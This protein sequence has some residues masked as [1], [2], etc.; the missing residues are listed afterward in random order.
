MSVKIRSENLTKI[1]GDH[2]DEALELLKQGHTRDEILKETGQTI[3]VYNASFEVNEGEI[4][5]LIGLSGSGKSS[6]IRCLNGLNKLTSGSLWVDEYAIHEMD[7]KQLRKLQ[8]DKMSMVFQHFAILPN[9]T[10]RENVGF[11]LEIRD[12]PKEERYR[13]T[14]EA[15]H[16][17]G[18]ET[19]SDK[20]PGDLSG[21]MKQRVGLARALI[22]NS[23][24]LLMDEPF[25]ALDALIRSEMQE[26]LINL[27]HEIK[28]TIVFVTHDLDEALHLGDKIAIMKD[29][30]IEQMGT[31]EEIL[32][33]P[34]NE[35]VANF[36]QSVDVS[37]ILVAENLARKPKDVLR[38]T[39]G[40]MLA[41][42]KFDRVDD[43]YMFVLRSNHTLKGIVFLDDIL[44]LRKQKEHSIEPAIKE[45]MYVNGSDV[46]Q[47]IY[48]VLQ[49]VERSAA[50]IDDKGKFIGE[51]TRRGIITGLAERRGAD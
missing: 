35:Y 12:I 14:Q 43:E 23:D 36:L 40:V 15:L 31:S 38:E 29:G 51:I 11:G 8:G 33:N 47:D 34:A 17:V 21:G 37:K 2:P 32:S 5:V 6:L 13:R 19:W 24:I 25:S 42:H 7:E 45:A 3:G 44:L 28:K 48:P 18:L 16:T 10:I 27:Q 50:V 46:L 1:Y 22:M 39:D 4:F 20:M 49:N 9:R 30:N 41:Y 26:E